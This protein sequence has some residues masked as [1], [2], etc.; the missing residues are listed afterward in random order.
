STACSISL[1]SEPHIC[2]SDFDHFTIIFASVQIFIS[3]PDLKSPI[4]R[5]RAE[6]VGWCHTSTSPS[7]AKDKA[8][9]DTRLEQRVV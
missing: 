4:Q 7:V 8:G 3:V 9:I 6:Q 1:L 2:G 5:V